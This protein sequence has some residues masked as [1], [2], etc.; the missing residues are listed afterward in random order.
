MF[1]DRSV[2]CPSESERP[3]EGIETYRPLVDAVQRGQQAG[4]FSS[5]SDPGVIALSVWGT[6]HG[7]VS[8]VPSGNEP[9]GLAVADCY[10]RA[11]RVLVAGWRES[12][13]PFQKRSIRPDPF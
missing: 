10:E 4:Q 9:P 13:G 2:E 12:E 6:A 7:L 11:L 5:E 8:L 1:S 3:R